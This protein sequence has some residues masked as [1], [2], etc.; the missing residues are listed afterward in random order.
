MKSLVDTLAGLVGWPKSEPVFD[1][2]TDVDLEFKVR[3]IRITVSGFKS[4]QITPE[5]TLA[6]TDAGFR[7]HEKFYAEDIR[8]QMEP[9]GRVTLSSDKDSVGKT[10]MR[11]E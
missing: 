5:M 3:G 7:L 1:P 8:D 9:V 4:E 6:L 11:S 10:V 2:E